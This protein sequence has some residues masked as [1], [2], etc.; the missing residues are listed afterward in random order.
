MT[1]SRRTGAEREIRDKD[2][3]KKGSNKLKKIEG[4][5]EKAEDDRNEKVSWLNQVHLQPS[6]HASQRKKEKALSQK[7]ES[8]RE[9]NTKA[10]LLDPEERKSLF[11]QEGRK[12]LKEMG[13]I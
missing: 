11:S 3:G 1:Y 5:G 6:N 12:D 7:E 10:H 2:G 4:S 8:G 9:Q 13:G